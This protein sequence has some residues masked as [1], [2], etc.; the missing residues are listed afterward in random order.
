MECMS[1]PH[2]TL[3]LCLLGT[4]APAQIHVV[5][6]EPNETKETATDAFDLAAGDSIYLPCI[7][8]PFNYFRVRTASLPMGVYR[9]VLRDSWQW[10]G[11]IRIM[12]SDA[13]I[14]DVLQ[15]SI[16][17]LATS[18]DLP[19]VPWGEEKHV[20]WYGFGKAEEVYVDLAPSGGCRYGTAAILSTTPVTVLDIGALPAS[21]P[22]FQGVAISARG[23]STTLV[24]TELHVFDAEFNAVPGGW[25]DDRWSPNDES[26][27]EDLRLPP[28]T[29][30]VAVAD[31]GLA[32]HLPPTAAVSELSVPSGGQ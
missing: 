15:G 10:G 6:V 8:S 4:V 5:G 9:H 27:I 19:S 18:S 25:N 2:L 22:P 14:D 17:E 28:G 21:T 26:G 13:L 20:A 32:T 3:A 29:Y 1:L 16:A 11:R 24:D 30:Y 7:S 23:A 12:G 31:K